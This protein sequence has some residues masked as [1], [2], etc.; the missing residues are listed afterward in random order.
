MGT[1]DEGLG[2]NSM[3]NCITELT[4]YY[5]GRDRAELSRGKNRRGLTGRAGAVRL[6]PMTGY[7]W[8]MAWRRRGLPFSVFSSAVCSARALLF[9]AGAL[10]IDAAAGADCATADGSTKRP[11]IIFPAVVCSTLV[12]TMS[13]VLLIILRAL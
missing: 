10:A 8:E 3:G 2:R 4:Q 1:P 13:M 5:C 11:K 9:A 12:T 7:V 6:Q